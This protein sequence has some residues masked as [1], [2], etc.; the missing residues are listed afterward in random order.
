MQHVRYLACGELSH[1]DQDS[2]VILSIPCVN[3]ILCL[4]TCCPT[5]ECANSDLL[6]CRR[7][8][9]H[10]GGIFAEYN[11]VPQINHII[12]VVG[13]GVED[14]IEF[15]VVR[16]SWGEQYNGAER[17][18]FRIVTSAYKDGRGDDYNLAVEEGCGWGV[19][20]AWKQASELGFGSMEELYL[21][22]NAEKF[23]R[24]AMVHPTV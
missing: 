12:S 4:Q 20:S 3:L 5:S 18:F 17:G 13:W 7:R 2:S 15:W 14:G 21:P 19:P 6:S 1:A 9:E 24:S 10:Q 22:S 16:N 11:P 8:D 23:S